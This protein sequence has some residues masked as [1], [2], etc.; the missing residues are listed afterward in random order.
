MRITIF[1]GA[2]T[3]ENPVYSE[4]T[5]SLAQWM[6]QNKHSLVYGGG[7]V[8]LMGVMADTVIAN[9][10]YTTGV[11]PT[12]LRDREIAHENLSELIIVNN[13]PERKAKMMLLGDAFIA[14]PG[15]PG[16][17]EEISEVISWSR[18]GQNDNPCILYNVNGYFNDLKNMFD[19]MVGEGFLSLEDRENVLFSDDIAEI[20]DFI[21][22]Y[23]V[24]STRQY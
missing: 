7:K 13:M 5:V 19:H 1:C 2:S 12:F 20:E 9:G 3:G 15:G 18:I 4:K 6:A 14:L 8:G 17:L 22:N 16:T 21:T 24:P 23:K 11:I 10:S